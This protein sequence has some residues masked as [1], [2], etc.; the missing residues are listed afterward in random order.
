MGQATRARHVEK[1]RKT[2]RTSFI[3]DSGDA[4]SDALIRLG[5]GTDCEDDY[6]AVA[7]VPS[8]KKARRLAM[9]CPGSVVA[10]IRMNRDSFSEMLR[11]KTQSKSRLVNPK[12]FT[13]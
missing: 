12:R 10:G 2:A 1:S 11:F 6:S 8:A 3:R 13:E 5:R 9:G 4:L 7:I